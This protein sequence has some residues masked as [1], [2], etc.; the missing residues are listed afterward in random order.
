MAA[1]EL[2]VIDVVMSP[3]PMPSNRRRMSSRLS[4][5]TP[6]RPT[7]PAARGSS[8]SRPIRVGRSKATDSPSA[9]WSRKKRY[10]A[11]VSSAVP[12]PAN[13]RC[14]HSLLRYIDAYGPRV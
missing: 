1:G 9:P 10:R 13:W 4:M 2:I 11:L 8:E 6:R 14:V 12:K 7:S 3:T 5:A